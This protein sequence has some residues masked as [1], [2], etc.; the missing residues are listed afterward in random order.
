MKIFIK[1]LENF[2][3]ISRQ[4]YK[5]SIK[6]SLFKKICVI[7]LF[8]LVEL[9][10]SVKS[11]TRIP[12]LLTPSVSHL[13][14]KGACYPRAPMH[15]TR[16]DIFVVV[17]RRSLESWRRHAFTPITCHSTLEWGECLNGGGVTV[18]VWHLLHIKSLIQ[19]WVSHE[20]VKFAYEMYIYSYI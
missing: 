10:L 20:N 5:F 15:A 17:V 8:S 18:T 12:V 13:G 4:T 11:L 1:I 14:F 16:L 6:S 9:I 7:D 2:L 3:T 19:N